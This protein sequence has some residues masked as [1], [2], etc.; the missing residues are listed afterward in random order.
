MCIGRVIENKRIIEDYYLLTLACEDI[1]GCIQEGQILHVQCGDEEQKDPLLRRPFS[2]YRFNRDKG[3]IQIMY[4]VKGKGT[5]VMATFKKGEHVSLIG[6]TGSHFEVAEGTKED[7]LLIYGR[8]VGIAAIVSLAE[9]ARRLERKTMVI[10]SGKT[11]KKIISKDYLEA[12][13]CQVI[14]VHDADGTSSV[15]NIE[16][17]TR[18]ALEKYHVK[19]LYTC[20]SNRIGRL[21]KRICDEYNVKGYISVE[22][23]M[24]CG[25]GVCFGCICKTA[26]GHKRVCTDGPVFNI[27][28]IEI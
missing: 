9:K 16:K 4:L 20:G 10:L 14:V 28:D 3:Q 25:I 21:F 5:R 7:S 8:G 1:A 6:P 23:H 13:G 24:A 26:Q 19:G 12:I 15:E 11:N 27:E 2:V 17:I 18:E 22:E